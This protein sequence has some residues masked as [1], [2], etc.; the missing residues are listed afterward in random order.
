MITRVE[1]QE[2]ELV[3]QMRVRELVA[4]V[5]QAHT[6]PEREAEAVREALRVG[7]ARVQDESA[8]RGARRVAKIYHGENDNVRIQ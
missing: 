8:A 7:P 2:M 4:E 1:L 3:A 5:E 6:A